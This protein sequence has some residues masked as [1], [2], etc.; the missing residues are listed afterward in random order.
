MGNKEVSPPLPLE[1][2]V[3]CMKD[4]VASDLEE[5]TQSDVSNYEIGGWCEE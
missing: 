1:A 4:I 2:A 5:M 3:N